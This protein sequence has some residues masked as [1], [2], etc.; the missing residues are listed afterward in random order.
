M[1]NMHG[2]IYRIPAK[3]MHKLKINNTN[4]SKR[5]SGSAN[6]KIRKSINMPQ[7]NTDETTTYSTIPFST[8]K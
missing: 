2:F 8:Q 3:Q 7:T 5:K 4:S 6:L 1:G